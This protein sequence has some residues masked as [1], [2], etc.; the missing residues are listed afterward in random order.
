M[1]EPFKTIDT[2]YPCICKDCKHSFKPQQEGSFLGFLCKYYIDLVEGKPIDCY[3]CRSKMIMCG[4]EGKD[5][6]AK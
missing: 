6:K 2:V 1:S 5:F 4:K 3:T